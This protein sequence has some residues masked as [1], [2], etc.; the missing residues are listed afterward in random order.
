MFQLPQD[1]AAASAH[2]PRYR[3]S[4][5]VVFPPRDLSMHTAVA[6]L[7]LRGLAHPRGASP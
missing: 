1:G 6:H 5:A 4:S 3:L 2:Q 7:A